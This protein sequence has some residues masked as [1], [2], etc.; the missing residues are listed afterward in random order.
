LPDVRAR[1]GAL[2][3]WWDASVLRLAVVAGED[4]QR[5]R[6]VL[7]RGK[8]ERVTAARIAFEVSAPAAVPGR[9]LESRRSA[10]ERVAAAEGRLREAAAE[11]DVATLWEIV[12]DEGDASIPAEQL[13]E[14]G[15][16]AAG[17]EN[18]A[19]VALALL[20]DGLHFVRRGDGFE[21]RSAEQ[22]AALRQDRERRALR[23][24]QASALVER[25]RAATQGATFQESGDAAEARALSTLEQLALEA[26]S[27]P[28]SIRAAGMELLGKVGLRY[29]RP[30]EGAFRLLRAVGRFASDDENLQLLRYRLRTS[31]PAEVLEVAAAAAA[32]GFSRNARTDCTDLQMVTIDSAATREIDDGLTLESRPGGAQRLG[33]H[34]SDPVAFIAPDDAV[35]REAAARGLTHYHPDC[36][37]TMLPAAISEGAASLALG[38]PRP[39]LSFFVELEPTGALGDWSIQ[40]TVVQA[41][42]RLDYDEADA[43]FADA[44]HEQ[45]RLLVELDRLAASRESH[46][47]SLGAL[48]FHSPEVEVHVTEAGQ[49]RLERR[50]AESVSRRVV[51]EAMVLAGDVGARFCQEARIPAIYRKQQAPA[52]LPEFDGPIVDPVTLR[53]VRRSL[54]RGEVALQ[55]GRHFALGLD[56]YV[57]VTS[58]LRRYQ[59]LVVQ[60]QISCTLRGLPPLYNES[61]MQRIAADTERAEQEARRAERAAE[62]Y[63]VLRYLEQQVGE[64]VEGIV[65][66]TQPRPFVQ[67]EETLWEQAMPA[68]AGCEAG[69]RVTLRIERVNPRAGI[70]ILR[71]SN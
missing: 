68:L 20:A 11:L 18:C 27:A 65:V 8:E 54:K 6:L 45:H 43:A 34:I 46:R 51:T 59:D 25:L 4:K 71:D 61:A 21:P 60:R 35:D 14:L 1:A 23:E 49:I 29:D 38:Q 26:D 52:T 69:Q 50:A 55:P 17:G 31:F 64:S 58:P 30:H 53:R 66:A 70:L 24:A 36:R 19:I 12:A 10:G 22:I 41:R 13:A 37:L 9:D 67:L 42:I 39:A 16:G 2:V 56:G 63:W 33:I 57:Q 44:N 32:A 48:P 7:E 40:R 15:L 3:A 47:I 28:D 62:E 5:I